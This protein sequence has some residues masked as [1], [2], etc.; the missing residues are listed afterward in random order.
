MKLYLTDN[1][2]DFCLKFENSFWFFCI[3]SKFYKA[4]ENKTHFVKVH[5]FGGHLTSKFCEEI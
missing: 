5:D 1:A 3:G 2:L 4:L